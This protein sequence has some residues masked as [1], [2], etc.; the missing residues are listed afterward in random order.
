MA[1]TQDRNG[2]KLPLKH[3]IGASPSLPASSPMAAMPDWAA[4]K[5]RIELEIIRRGHTKGFE[6]LPQRWV[7]ERTCACIFKN[8]RLVVRVRR[9]PLVLTV[10]AASAGYAA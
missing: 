2:G 5:T 6:V 1:P 10:E 8:W 9:R 4:D 3:L 7:V